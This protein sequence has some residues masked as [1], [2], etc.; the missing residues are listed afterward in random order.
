MLHLPL[1]L[2]DALDAFQLKLERTD[3]FKKQAPEPV[4]VEDVFRQGLE[5]AFDKHGLVEQFFDTN[6]FVMP[7]LRQ[8][9]E[10]LGC[11]IQKKHK[12]LF[13]QN[14]LKADYLVQAQQEGS[15]LAVVNINGR[16]M[17]DVLQ[18]ALLLL[19][20]LLGKESRRVSALLT[21]G[22]EWHFCYLEGNTLHL[23]NHRLFTYDV[24][25]LGGAM[26]ALLQEEGSLV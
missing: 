24:E 14:V 13:A 11:K 10:P 20:A 7:I 12:V 15:D 8:V 6:F 1:S 17:D 18:E 19:V 22:N 16:L 2:H 4:V 9:F 21:D 25:I 5:L 23:H 26:R 3:L